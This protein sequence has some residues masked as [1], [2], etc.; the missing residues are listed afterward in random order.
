M[1]HSRVYIDMTKDNNRITVCFKNI[2]AEEM[3]FSAREITER[4]VRGDRS[5]NSEGSGLGMAIAQSF[6]EL[7]KG[8]FRV[9]TDGD[10]FKV[11]ISWKT[12]KEEKIEALEEDT[13]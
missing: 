5:R 4:F 12:E 13:E 6:T 3:N 7:Q 2:S 8:S 9:E 1:E 11:T 10:L